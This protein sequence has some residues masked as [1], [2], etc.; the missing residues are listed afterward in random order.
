MRTG[1]A[2]KR[3]T[4]P[5]RQRRDVRVQALRLI[6][7]SPPPPCLPSLGPQVQ[8][9]DL[10]SRLRQLEH[11]CQICPHRRPPID[12][13]S[14]LVIPPHDLVVEGRRQPQRTTAHDQAIP[15]GGVPNHEPHCARRLVF[16]VAV[17]CTKEV[18]S[19]LADREL[20]L[21]RATRSKG[22]VFMLTRQ[23]FPPVISGCALD[24]QRSGSHGPHP[25][26]PSPR[27]PGAC[28]ELTPKPGSARGPI[29]K[30]ETRLRPGE[31]MHSC[32]QLLQTLRQCTPLPNAAA[33]TAGWHQACAIDLC[34]GTVDAFRHTTRTAVT[35]SALPGA[36]PGET[37]AQPTL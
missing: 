35:P 5:R 14:S 17:S 24:V 18:H 34:P 30:R 6:E 13:A 10:L 9:A 8:H 20:K 37:I 32:S 31:R 23:P 19:R 29:A 36:C 33:S 16:Q 4:G 1:H 25:A 22:I 11:P 26:R 27:Q 21:Y 12:E 3:P 15:V 7:V 28:P 2:S